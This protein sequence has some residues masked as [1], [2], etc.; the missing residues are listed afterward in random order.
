MLRLLARDIGARDIPKID[1][2]ELEARAFSEHPLLHLW[3]AECEGHLIGCLIAMP[4]YSTWRGRTGLYV[5]DL[6]VDRAKRRLAVGEKLMIRAAQDA[7]A[8]G[9]SFIRLEVTNTN[10]DAIRFYDR[11]GFSPAVSDLT[12]VLEPSQMAQFVKRPF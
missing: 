10:I 7:Y 12:L 5:I 9:L 2:D 3:V 11:L 1:G 8:N 4:T 6:Y